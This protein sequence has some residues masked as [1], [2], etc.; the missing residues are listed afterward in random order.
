MVQPQQ[1][2]D[3][4]KSDVI[5]HD[6]A[7]CSG[8]GICELMC[9]L[10]HEGE[11]SPALARGVLERDPFNAE[12]EFNACRQCLAPSCYISCPFP[13][14]AIK[15]DR[16][17][18]VKYIVDEE[19]TGCKKCIRACPVNPPGL[20]FNAEKKLAFKCDL[21]RGREQGPICVEY[22]PQ[23][24]LSLLQAKRRKDNGE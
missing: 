16:Q 20:K 23:G 14:K 15:V 5:V 11:V 17:T 22:C 2:Y 10:Y 19:C 6:P 7:I 8:C 1:K 13:D 4:P 9:S 3:F 18:G 12:Y 21:C 24:A